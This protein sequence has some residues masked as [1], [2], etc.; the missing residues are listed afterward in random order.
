MVSPPMHIPNNSTPPGTSLFLS[1]ALSPLQ[2]DLP[3]CGK[4]ECSGT[5]ARTK[6]GAV[7][8]VLGVTRSSTPP[9]SYPVYPIS[10]TVWSGTHDVCDEVL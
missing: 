9:V 5:K 3:A 10:I 7:C 2:L 8:P 6:T 1:P 4:L